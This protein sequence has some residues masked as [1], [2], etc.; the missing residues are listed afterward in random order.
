M[1]SGYKDGS[2][3]GQW[4]GIELGNGALPLPSRYRSPLCNSLP[5]CGLGWLPRAKVVQA[6]EL[7][8]N[9]SL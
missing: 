9:C 4:L 6:L 2:A 8:L 1:P 7:P 5:F 3:L